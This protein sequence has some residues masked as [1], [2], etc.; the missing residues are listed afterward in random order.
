MLS[1]PYGTNAKA[2]PYDT[3]TWAAL[4]SS[5]TGGAGIYTV[6]VEETDGGLMAKSNIVTITVTPGS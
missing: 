1:G 6:W 3:T 4:A 2:P 5:A